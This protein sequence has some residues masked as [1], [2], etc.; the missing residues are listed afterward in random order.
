[1]RRSSIALVSAFAAGALEPTGSDDARDR[2]EGG[3]SITRSAVPTWLGL[4][5]GQRA[6]GG[7]PLS[8]HACRSGWQ[9]PDSS[10]RA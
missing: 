6:R 8:R 9:A 7:R 10:P 2:I 4:G 1:M 3:V 5:R